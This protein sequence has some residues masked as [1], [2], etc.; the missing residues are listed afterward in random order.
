MK[1]IIKIPFSIISI[2]I[3]IFLIGCSSTNTDT[4]EKRE[5]NF[6]QILLKDISGIELLVEHCNS[7]GMSYSYFPQIL[8]IFAGDNNGNL[9]GL[10]NLTEGQEDYHTLY[11]LDTMKKKAYPVYHTHSG[12]TIRDADIGSKY[13]VWVESGH[14]EQWMNYTDWK[15]MALDVTTGQEI[16][17]DEGEYGRKAGID[18]P[19]IDME[20][21]TIVYDISQEAAD[22]PMISQVIMCDLINNSK[23]VLGEVEGNNQYLGAPQ[24][25]DNRVVWNRGEWTEDVESEVSLYDISTNEISQLPS[26]YEAMEP[27]IWGE[28]VLWSEC[29][30]GLEA[31]NIVKY[32]L[33][34]GSSVNITDVREEDHLENWLLSQY[35]GYVTWV[36]N[37]TTT[38][39]VLNLHTDELVR[40]PVPSSYRMIAGN[41]F[42][43]RNY[44]SDS[45][46]QWG[47]CIIDVDTLFEAGANINENTDEN[48]YSS[49]EEMIEAS[50]LIIKGN[51]VSDYS[52]RVVHLGRMAD[53]SG[54]SIDEAYMV[55]DIQITEVIKGQVQ[56]GEIIQVKQP[57]GIRSASGQGE[58]SNYFSLGMQGIFFLNTYE[59]VPATCINTSQGF[60][61][62]KEGK[63]SVIEGDKQIIKDCVE[64]TTLIK[65][66]KQI[67]K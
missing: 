38:P 60:V 62:I 8:N 55:S 40:V 49:M 66:I 67:S 4:K 23:K 31:D 42:V 28:Y 43:W 46:P 32:N 17:I 41:Y 56:P 9:L 33:T 29:Q 26:A 21:D 11:L 57:G 5:Y 13:I 15:I 22:S 44:I 12:Y 6:K 37:L 51:V 24:I 63:T 64:D 36:T 14:D 45:R 18:W 30:I 25:D 39:F 19:D 58:E 10:V 53:S 1:K 20:S 2:L 47:W 16:I 3:C 34:A 52:P 7:E 59:D 27:V 48:V 61:R 54:L 50:D 65:Q 35:D